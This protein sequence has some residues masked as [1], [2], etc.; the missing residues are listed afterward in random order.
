MHIDD[1]SLVQGHLEPL[2][3]Q[4]MPDSGYENALC[5]SPNVV[6]PAPTFSH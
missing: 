2:D 6:R 3:K 1:D 5:T 4:Q